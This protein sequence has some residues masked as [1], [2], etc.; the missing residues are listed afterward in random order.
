MIKVSTIRLDNGLTL[1]HNYNAATR[2]VA[3]N[4]L[5]DVGSRDEQPEHTGLAHLM[6]HLMF[7]G[8]K[9][10]P[11][12]DGALQAAGGTNNAWTSV[13]VTNYYDIVPAHNIETALWLERDRL[14]NL[15]LDSH[16]IELQKSVVI[17]EFKQRYL[18]QPYG[19][20][21]HLLNGE[22]FKVHP[23]RVPTI[24]RN[25]DDIRDV[26][27]EVV[28]HFF[29]SHY[30]VNNMV[31]CIAGS[32]PLERALE[33]VK[34]WFGDIEPVNIEPR[35]L[36]Q[37]PPQREPRLVVSDERDV[38]SNILWR[39]YHMCDRLSSDFAATDLLSDVLANGPSSRFK[40]SEM[41]KSGM[42]SEL[43]ASVWGTEDPGLFYIRA[44]LA[45][46]VD[47]DTAAAAL[48][49]ELNS[50]L[51]EGVTEREVTKYANK[52]VTTQQFENVGNDAKAARL[53]AF[54]N[55]SSADDINRE[56]ELYR[57][58]TAADVN[59]V[60]RAIL[61]PSNCT[62]LLYRKRP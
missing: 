11:S 16:S 30:A 6:E 44:R 45:D 61:R 53:C 28:Q 41:I 29:R 39:A 40:Q 62:T 31:L 33:L 2:M 54:A 17:E 9:N 37:E 1:L 43:D 50:L 27:V 24:G 23:Y 25:V 10:A 42:M 20:F 55:R 51:D 35:R 56:P 13:D 7:T 15:N 58:T 8:S 19:D 18:N 47:F 34:K 3:L 26:P 52:F 32:V 22:A 38:P 5:Y 14:L 57:A 36:P 4:I 60:A 48:D 46:G 12:F 49:A 21:Y 59:R